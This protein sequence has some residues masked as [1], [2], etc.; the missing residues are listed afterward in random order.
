MTKLWSLSVSVLGSAFVLLAQ[1][2]PLPPTPTP[3]PAVATTTAV[4]DV[5]PKGAITQQRV[6]ATVRWLAHDDRMGRDTPSPELEATADWIGERFAAAGLEQVVPD[7]WFHRYTLP[8]VRLDS[9]AIAVVV[10]RPAG[11]GGDLELVP[12]VDVRLWRI[13]DSSAGIDEQATVALAEDPRT[14]RL[15]D[16]AA[17]RRP[18][19][20][21]VAEDHPYWQRAAGV[22]DEL[23]TRRAAAKPMFLV[24]KGA[25]PQKEAK[26]GKVG[27][28][29]AAMTLTWSTAAAEPVEL[30]LR[31]V[32]AMRRGTTRPDEIVLVSAHYDHIGIGAPVDG[33][34][35]RN[36]ADDDASGTTAVL[37]LAEAFAA[38]PAP[39]RS[40]VFVCFSGEEKGL[41]GSRAFA[42]APPF[43]LERIVANCNIEMIGR[44]ED[45][46]R[47]KA[48]VTGVEL[49]D[50]A[51][52]IAPALAKEDVEL[53]DFAMARQLFTASDNASLAAHGIVAHSISAGS[54]HRDYH[55]P[56]DE[57]DKLDL[58]HMTTIIR[59]LKAAVWALADSDARPAFNEQGRAAIQRLRR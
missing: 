36:G 10:K 49:S 41:R 42:Q 19:L 34:R 21:E 1:A 4:V 38:Q 27:D 17:G 30:P 51:A 31:N 23:G 33:D 44:P 57:V 18:V 46:K 16:A 50:F 45:G 59:A 48:W 39:A 20:L 15:L 55:Q 53:V 8:G 22:R 2:P 37:L 32:V 12:D 13:G 25:L 35:I 47:H 43:P 24:R 26:D 7:S 29:D 40:V 54:L 3:G 5:A 28:G 56:G 6:E 58:P 9:R 52:L 14:A 11:A